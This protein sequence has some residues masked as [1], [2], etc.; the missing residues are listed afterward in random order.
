MQNMKTFCTITSESIP[1]I[2]F[3]F[4]TFL[5]ISQAVNVPYMDEWYFTHI[6]DIYYKGK[7]TLLI[8][9]LPTF[10]N[11]IHRILFPRLIMLL[12]AI[13]TK[14]DIRYELAINLLLGFLTYLIYRFYFYKNIS[15]T[16][17]FKY[18]ILSVVAIFIFSFK[19]SENWGWGWQ[20]QIFLC[21]F[22]S[23]W[24]I[25]LVSMR[26][27]SWVILAISALLA[28]I[29]SYSFTDGLII[30]IVA[31]IVLLSKKSRP[32]HLLA[33]A[34]MGGAC[35]AL[36]FHG[37]ESKNQL[38]LV[39]IPELL[40]FTFTYLGSPVGNNSILQSFCAGVTGVVIA[41]CL[42]LSACSLSFNNKSITIASGAIILY[43]LMSALVTGIGRF[44]LGM[45][46]GMTSRYS[47]FA[48]HF[49]IAILLLATL[50]FDQP[51]SPIQKKY[52][53]G[54]VLLC[55]TI[56]TTSITTSFINRYGFYTAY[57]RQAAVNQLKNDVDGN[58]SDMLNVCWSMDLLLKWS[59]VLKKYHL[60][61]YADD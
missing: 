60:S 9:T 13:A 16:N 43:S 50:H 29:A 48:V 10:H 28:F 17:V 5:V 7:F 54:L 11:N 33:W 3:G 53:L 19:Q 39:N 22:A 40:G 14:W 35:F 41:I 32:H 12:L 24:V 49:W 38:S 27:C 36:Y 20:I 52:R 58:K 4:L 6:L 42:F 56:V 55:V 61:Y 44:D 25:C 8:N 51:G 34:V 31:L 1:L 46:T 2:I 47:T 23:I 21:A 37:Y 30:W 59:P 26:D 15:T 45:E 18:I 57:S